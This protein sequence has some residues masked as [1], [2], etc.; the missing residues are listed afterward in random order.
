MDVFFP[1]AYIYG[2]LNPYKTL[3]KVYRNFLDVQVFLP[4]LQQLRDMI[5]D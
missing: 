1:A 4:P 5:N 2:R 3:N